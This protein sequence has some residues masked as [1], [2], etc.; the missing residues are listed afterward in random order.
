MATSSLPWADDR[1]FRMAVSSQRDNQA[2]QLLWHRCPLAPRTAGRPSNDG[3]TYA[4]FVPGVPVVEL[5]VRVGCGEI[6]RHGSNPTPTKPSRSEEHTS[7]LQSH[8]NL[9]CSLLLE[10]KKAG[11]IPRSSTKNKQIGLLGL[12]VFVSL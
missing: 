6:Q 8:V 10:K 11:Q 2:D 3:S 5:E 12:N 9:V 1:P 4:S 7:E